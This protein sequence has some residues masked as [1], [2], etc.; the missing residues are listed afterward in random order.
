MSDDRF[1]VCVYGLGRH[2]RAVLRSARHVA[3]ADAAVEFQVVHHTVGET[4][5]S[6]ATSAATPYDVAII[7]NNCPDTSGI[8]TCFN[9]RRSDS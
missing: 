7:S 1:G 4:A 2:G 6:D 3:L 5:I 9:G 8:Q